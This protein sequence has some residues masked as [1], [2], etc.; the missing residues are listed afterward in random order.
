MD[1]LTP[2]NSRAR[3]EH[4][5]SAAQV[6]AGLVIGAVSLM[7]QG[8]S[9]MLLANLHAAGRISLT[10]IGWAAFAEAIALTVASSAAG[11]WLRPTNL[12]LV[13]FAALAALALTD[14]LVV[15]SPR[16]SA[17]LLTR[18]SAGLAEGVLFWISLGLITRTVS[19]Q[20]WA[21]VMIIISTIGSITAIYIIQ[22]DVVPAMRGSGGF[23][24][25]AGLSLLTGFILPLLPDYY[26]SL[27]ETR[28]WSGFPPPRGCLALGC[29]L[30]Y[31]AAGMG[32]FVYLIPVAAGFGLQPQMADTALAALLVGQI[33]GSLAA[34]V[35]SGTLRT[36]P[37]LFVSGGAYLCIWLVFAF[38]TGSVVFILAA[39]GNGLINFF[40]SPY[41]YP[42]A[43]DADPSRRAAMQSGSA[44]MLGSAVSPLLA[45]WAIASCGLSG[46]FL[47]SCF[48]LILALAILAW[49]QATGFDRP[50]G[51]RT[52]T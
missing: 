46:L 22:H 14:L 3:V 26:P 19:V 18:I 13:A 27:Y 52:A 15:V 10:G 43:I 48:L 44:Q 20:R 47:L 36:A 16:E 37:L 12:R 9:P 34:V 25:L 40:A 21:A 23:L 11:A 8:A 39:F 6:L 2:S 42:L 41:L 28:G 50:K 35:F 33:A 49:L 24:V 7:S 30:L 5:F 45:A 1:D 32:Y 31:T 4:E 29:I 17:L 51:R 38:G